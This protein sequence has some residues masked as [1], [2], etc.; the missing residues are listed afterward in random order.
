[1]VGEKA[2]SILPKVLPLYIEDLLEPN[3][4]LDEL[5]AKILDEI[6][7]SGVFTAYVVMTS[8]DNVKSDAIYNACDNFIHVMSAH[9]ILERC[10]KVMVVHVM[11]KH[12]H[13]PKWYI[14]PFFDLE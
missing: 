12:K 10:G 5:A 13:S 14:G 3:I 7:D 9:Y 1:M 11:D 2:E 6:D 4:S 8:V